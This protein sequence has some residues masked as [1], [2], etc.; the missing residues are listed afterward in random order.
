MKAKEAP[1]LTLLFCFVEAA[2]LLLLVSECFFQRLVSCLL[3]YYVIKMSSMRILG[4]EERFVS[5][6]NSNVEEMIKVGR[7]MEQ[8]KQRK[9]GLFALGART[10]ETQLRITS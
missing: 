3:A 6:E 7:R 2:Y 5:L 10:S 9:V 4:V 8:I 1:F